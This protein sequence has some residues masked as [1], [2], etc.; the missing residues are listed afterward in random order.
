MTKTLQFMI[1]HFSLKHFVITVIVWIVTVSI[2]V[3]VWELIMGWENTDAALQT[4]KEFMPIVVVLG[5]IGAYENAKGR[6]RGIIE[7][8]FSERKTWSNWYKRNQEEIKEHCTEF[9]EPTESDLECPK[10][11]GYHKLLKV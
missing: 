5:L 10:C 9:Q 11:G 7:G 1:K 3:V 8:K 2:L 4:F 6:R